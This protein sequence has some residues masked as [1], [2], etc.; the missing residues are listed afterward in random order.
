MPFSIHAPA[1]ILAFS[2]PSAPQ[3]LLCLL[4]TEPAIY[5][6]PEFRNAIILFATGGQVRI[7]QATRNY[8]KAERCKKNT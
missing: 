3:G 2:S 8:K 7:P 4:V 6:T 1:G 5:L